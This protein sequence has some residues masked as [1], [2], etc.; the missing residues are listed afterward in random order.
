MS[1]VSRDDQGTDDVGQNVAEMIAERSRTDRPRGFDIGE[2][3][4][5]KYLPAYQTRHAHPG[6]QAD[7]DEHK[8]QTTNTGVSAPGYKPAF[9][10]LALKLVRKTAISRMI[11]SKVGK[12]YIISTMRMRMLSTA[13]PT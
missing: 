12:A 10:A 8:Q 3:A 9:P 2:F 6:R 5:R 7:A 11:S 13:P 1:R 4:Y